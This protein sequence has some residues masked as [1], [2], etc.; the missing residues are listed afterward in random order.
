MP[1]LER[2]SGRPVP[3]RC[4]GTGTATALDGRPRNP[5][6]NGVTDV[7]FGSPVRIHPVIT[8]ESC[9]HRTAASLIVGIRI[10]LEHKSV[11][12]HTSES[13]PQRKEAGDQ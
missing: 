5:L 9:Q 8:S 2:S 7:R 10:H 1:A 6:L 11:S 12:S 13:R 4:V 3:F